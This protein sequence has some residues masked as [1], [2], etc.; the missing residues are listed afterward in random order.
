ME[1]TTTTPAPSV[2]CAYCAGSGS[3]YTTRAGARRCMICQG[4]GRIA[5]VSCHLC[6]DPILDGQPRKWGVKS[7]MSHKDC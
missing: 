1:T 6:G 2:K 7:I 5:P 3:V 4:T